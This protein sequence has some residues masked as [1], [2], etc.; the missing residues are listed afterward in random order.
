[1]EKRLL[2]TGFE[3]FGGETVNPSWEAVKLL[4]E[5]I[6]DF[7]LRKLCIPVVFGLA[8]DTVWETAQA[9]TPDVILCVGQAGGR[10][11][12]TPEKVGINLR[13]GSLA[14]NAGNLYRE[15]PAVPG[16]PAA[17]FSTLPVSRMAQAVRDLEIPAAVSYSAGTFV[18]NDTLYTLLHRCA[19]SMVKVGFIH[20][21]YLPQ[22]AGKK[23]PSLPLE[24]MARGLEAAISA[25]E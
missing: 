9:Y 18:C 12:I 6:G 16:A 20:V 1:M 11:A 5:Q 3:P 19:G 22:Q 8:A 24:I 23:A 21:P 4:P 10:A 14:D 25:I 17:Y 15:A 7:C 13:E 2:I